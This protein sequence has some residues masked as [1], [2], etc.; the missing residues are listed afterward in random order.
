MKPRIAIIGEYDECLRA[1]LFTS[2]ALRHSADLLRIEMEDE[3]IPTTAITETS[4][5]DFDAVWLA[6]GQP[7]ASFDAS[8]DVLRHARETKLPCLATCR[9]FQHMVLELARNVVGVATAA[10]AEYEPEA[11]DFFISAMPPQ[12]LISRARYIDI[13]LRSPVFPMYSKKRAPERFFGKYGVNPKVERSLEMAR[14]TSMAS[15][16]I[17]NFRIGGLTNHPFYIGTMFLP[18]LR[19]TIMLPHPLVTAF[20]KAAASSKRFRV[21]KA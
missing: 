14:F 11:T 17:G 9:G 16:P 15:E 7:Y 18:Q 20:L 13:P 19:S 12:P 3:W 5:E 8:L 10:H 4:L 21:A 6:A 1:H 2:Q